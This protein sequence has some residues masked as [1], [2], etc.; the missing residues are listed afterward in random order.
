MA[1]KRSTG[2]GAEA[3]TGNNEPMSTAR[4]VNGFPRL[5]DRVVP[6]E[7]ADTAV[8]RVDFNH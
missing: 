4:P 8:I 3:P 5:E 6:A 2:K 7:V 1:R